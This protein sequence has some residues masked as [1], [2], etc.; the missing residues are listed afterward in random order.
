MATSCNLNGR[1]WDDMKVIVDKYGLS[2]R[3]VMSASDL[4]DVKDVIFHLEE[5]LN[6][7]IEHEAFNEGFLTFTAHEDQAKVPYRVFCLKRKYEP[8]PPTDVNPRHEATLFIP[9]RYI[10]EKLAQKFI[11]KQD[12]QRLWFQEILS[13][14]K[15]TR[16]AAGFI[17]ETTFKL[18]AQRKGLRLKL[19]AMHRCDRGTWRG[20]SS[21]K[22]SHCTFTDKHVDFQSRSTDH[23][24]TNFG[25]DEFRKALDTDT[26]GWVYWEPGTFDDQSFDCLLM[27]MGN[28]TGKAYYIQNA[29]S[30][31]YGTKPIL[32]EH[33]VS[34]QDNRAWEEFFV[35][36]NIEEEITCSKPNVGS[37]IKLYFAS[38]GQSLV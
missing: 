10:S 28:S 30:T 22:C 5:C 25:R 8:N 4:A 13:T 20:C 9:T 12:I 26:E 36:I 24:A 35:L 37:G 38:W 32:D 33:R 3:H 17:Y 7:A 18:T 2:V 19:W 23:T 21:D 16:S 27:N 1:K 34:V 15:L 31:P 29:I 11:E 14:S 6:S